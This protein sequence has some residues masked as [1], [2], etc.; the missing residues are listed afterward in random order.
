VG[1]TGGLV[2]LWDFE[3]RGAAKELEGGHAADAAVVCLAWSRTGF[4]LASGAS[5]GS[6]LVWDVLSGQPVSRA[7]VQGVPVCGVASARSPP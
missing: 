7:K 3:T 1:C 4:R 6:L 2:V 5:D